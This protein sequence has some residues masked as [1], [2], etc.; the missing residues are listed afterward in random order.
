MTIDEYAEGKGIKEDNFC[1]E[2]EWNLRNL[3]SIVGATA[4]K[5]GIYYSNKKK[6]YYVAKYWERDKLKDFRIYVTGNEVSVASSLGKDYHVYVVFKPNSS[7]PEIFDLGNPF[8]EEGKVTLI[9]INYKLHL[10]KV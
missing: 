8:M 10:K 4:Q 1:Y 6:G 7:R 2:I 3:G 9:P 5:F